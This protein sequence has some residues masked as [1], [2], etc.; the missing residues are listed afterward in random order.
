MRLVARLPD[1]RQVGALVDSLRNIGLDRGD[2]IISNLADEQK[3]SSVE[4][5][6]EA[7]VSMIKTERNGLNDLG[8]F[9][10]GVKGLKGE[11]GILVAVKMPKHEASKVREIMEQSGAVEIVQD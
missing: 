5:A 6:A 8:T 2:M 9:A 1:E 7:G 10:E 4:E 11:E 3:F